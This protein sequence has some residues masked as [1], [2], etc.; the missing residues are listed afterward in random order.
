VRERWNT[1]IEPQGF[2]AGAAAVDGSRA[3]LLVEG[4]PARRLGGVLAWA[5]RA[6]ASE[7]HVL[8]DDSGSAGIMA[9]RAT[10][11]AR[12]PQVWRVNA[13]ALEA[14]G[15]APSPTFAAPHPAAELE[16]VLLSDAGLE[17]V[18]EQGQ[19]IGEL[20]GLE[21]ARVVIGPDPSTGVDRPHIEA[22]VGRFDREQFALMHADLSPPEAIERV[23]EIVRGYRH[24]GAPPHP[25][26][27]LV[28]E[29]WLRAALVVDPSL[30]SAAEL[31]PVESA[32]P[33][34]NLRENLPA[35]AI[36]TDLDGRPVV[37]VC[38]T[39]VDL[40][41]VP[42]GADDR[43]A[44]LPNGR[45]VLVVP[46]RDVA[47]VTTRLAGALRQRADVIGVDGDWRGWV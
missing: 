6:G 42:T 21:V 47:S 12:P 5:N 43:L 22:G 29:R 18:V 40:E 27:Q 26:N 10:E 36:G 2:P 3:W 4:E 11:F 39:G 41:L 1:S 15:S 19:I 44:H 30:V 16:A 8:V 37:V 33:R 45:L 46:E 25:L 38:S 32:V 20:R 35:T 31:R 9:R 24:A 17:V 23:I 13:R 7:V 28:P 34:Q 14:V